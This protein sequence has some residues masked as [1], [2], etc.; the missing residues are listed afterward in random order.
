MTLERIHGAIGRSRASLLEEM[1]YA[2][3]WA[4]VTQT[5]TF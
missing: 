2:K 4:M 5:M 3:A 1:V